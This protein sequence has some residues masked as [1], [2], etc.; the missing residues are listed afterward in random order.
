MFHPFFRGQD[1]RSRAGDRRIVIGGD[2]TAA[3]TCRQV[4]DQISVLLPDLPNNVFVQADLH[5]WFGRLRIT[6]VNVGNCGAGFGS[7]KARIGNLL[8]RCR[9]VRVLVTGGQVS[10]HGA[11]DDGF[12][13]HGSKPPPGIDNDAR[14]RGV[15]EVGNGRKDRLA[16]VLGFDNLSWTK[17]WV[18]RF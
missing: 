16:D 18:S 6:H 8:R 1:R 15:G 14:T 3:W 10:G 7:L 13:H 2:E 5:R 12:V 11:G 17:T 4:E 9:Q